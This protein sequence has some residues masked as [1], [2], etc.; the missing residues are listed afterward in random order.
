MTE[1]CVH[2]G[3]DLRLH[4]DD[5]IAGALET[6][7]AGGLKVETL[8]GSLKTLSYGG[9]GAKLAKVDFGALE[10][11]IAGSCAGNVFK[12]VM[13]DAR[14]QVTAQIKALGLPPGTTFEVDPDL[15]ASADGDTLHMKIRLTPPTPVSFIPITVHNVTVGVDR[16]RKDAFGEEF[17]AF[18]KGEGNG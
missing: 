7:I 5:C 6:P 2:C 16:E 11:R 1:K 13:D 15:D 3:S 10:R 12:S 18:V 17:Q 14:A 8:E 9:L 4:T